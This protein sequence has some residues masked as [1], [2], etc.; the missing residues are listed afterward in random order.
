MR[1]ISRVQLSLLQPPAHILAAKTIPHAP[2]LLYSH[3]FPE[4]L[5]RFLAYGI[6]GGNARHLIVN[7]ALQDK[8]GGRRK[9]DLGA[10]EEIGNHSEVSVYGELIRSETGVGK[11]VAVDVSEND[12]GGAGSGGRCRDV[13]VD[14]GAESGIVKGGSI[15]GIIKYYSC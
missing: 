9:R 11:G 13:R 6:H 4:I 15:V 14:C 5:D 3:F 8:V 7:I 2:D 10:V 12:D 1:H